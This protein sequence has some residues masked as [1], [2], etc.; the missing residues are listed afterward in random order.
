[1]ATTTLPPLP[2]AAVR[3]RW[4][5]Q[6]RLAHALLLL[7]GVGLAVFLLAPLAMIL[8]KSLQDKDGMY[9]GLRQFEEY[10]RTP[11]LRQSILNTLTVASIVTFITIPLAF[12]Y[13]YALT[14]SAMPAGGCSACSH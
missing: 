9:V 6:D 11:A 7:V 8:V 1:M 10:F 3:P 5:W 14:R 4:H 13:A 2:R 12:V